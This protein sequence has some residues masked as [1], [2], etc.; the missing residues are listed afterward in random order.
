MNLLR[1]LLNELFANMAVF[2]T[3][4][5]TALWTIREFTARA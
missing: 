1:V 3:H 5:S 2:V 4:S